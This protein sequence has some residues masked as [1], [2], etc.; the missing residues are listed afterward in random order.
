MEAAARHP[1]WDLA[2]KPG[3]S[4]ACQLAAGGRWRVTG[5]GGGCGC[6]ASQRDPRGYRADMGEPLLTLTPPSRPAVAWLR[7]SVDSANAVNNPHAL[8]LPALVADGTQLV[9]AYGRVLM[10][11]DANSG[12][13]LRC[14]ACRACAYSGCHRVFPIP[15]SVR[16]WVCTQV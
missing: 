14:A 8:P 13:I 4:A 11:Y 3:E 2:F 9:V 15:L 10:V 1:I 6:S 16:A 7:R 5:W 12:E